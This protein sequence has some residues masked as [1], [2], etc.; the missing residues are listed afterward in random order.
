MAAT[1]TGDAKDRATDILI[2]YFPQQGQYPPRH[3]VELRYR[4]TSLAE[5]GTRANYMEIRSRTQYD[6]NARNM[7]GSTG[8]FSDSLPD[9]PR[10]LR[11]VATLRRLVGRDLPVQYNGR[12]DPEIPEEWLVPRWKR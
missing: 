11:A 8:A 1:I 2:R 12:P 4:Y 5:P 6:P 9:V 7:V 10:L 3:S